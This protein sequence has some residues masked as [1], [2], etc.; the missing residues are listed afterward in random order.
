MRKQGLEVVI[1]ASVLLAYVVSV[2]SS[3]ISIFCQKSALTAP[4][5]CRWN[6]GVEQDSDDVLLEQRLILRA[7]RSALFAL[8]LES[9]LLCP[10]D[11]CPILNNS[12]PVS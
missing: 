9:S 2:G 1:L 6:S 7:S 11:R 8:E 12:P 10:S 3:D 5:K 4:V